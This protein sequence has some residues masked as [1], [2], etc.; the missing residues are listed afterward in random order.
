MVY[1]CFK[2][3]HT[4]SCTEPSDFG[5]L[6]VFVLELAILAKSSNGLISLLP[7]HYPMVCMHPFPTALQSSVSISLG[8]HWECGCLTLK[9]VS[10][11]RTRAGQVAVPT[12]TSASLS[13]LSHQPLPRPT[14]HV[15]P[16][17]RYH[18]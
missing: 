10:V 15:L 11:D 14:Y 1:V 13:A 8:G 7:M 5:T 16:I 18:C 3:L 9:C 12:Y 2:F 4:L 17:E 6:A